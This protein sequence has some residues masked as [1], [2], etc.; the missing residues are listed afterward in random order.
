MDISKIE[1]GN[2]ETVNVF[3]ECMKNTKDLYEYDVETETFILKKV[4]DITFPGAYGFIPQTHHVDA[5]PLDVLVLSSDQ[6]QQGI[7]LP[8]RPIGVIRLKGNIPDDVLIAVPIS[9]KSF[10]R[11]NDITKINNLESIKNFLEGFKNL[12]VEFVFNAEHA[13]R[14]VDIAINLYK[15]EFG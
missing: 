8:S 4:L 6:V 11:I 9:D 2:R 12:K 1:P 10:E 13:R 5:K 14:S 7:V 3:I 15:K